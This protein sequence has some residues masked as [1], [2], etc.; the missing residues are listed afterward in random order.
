M[1]RYSHIYCILWKKS[2]LPIR[3]TLKQEYD[4]F[5]DKKNSEAL[6]QI[7]RDGRM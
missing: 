6:D 5:F 1:E 3:K 2:N 7:I 4:A